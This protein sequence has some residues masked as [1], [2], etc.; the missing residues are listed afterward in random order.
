M[1]ALLRR[2][3]S[4]RMGHRIRYRGCVQGERLRCQAMKIGM[5]QS[6]VDLYEWLPG[7]GESGISVATDGLNLRVTVRYE[8][9]GANEIHVIERELT[10]IYAPVFLR[11]PLR[12]EI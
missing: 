9:E 8:R 2:L 12:T 6:V 1:R 3:S 10:F 7:Y 11:H 4:G 5:L